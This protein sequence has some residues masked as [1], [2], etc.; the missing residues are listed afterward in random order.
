MRKLVQLEGIGVKF[1]ELLQQAGIEDQRELLEA[2]K[3][4]KGRETLAQET[5][6]NP[7]LLL[8]WTQQADLARI[9]GIG[10]DYAELLEQSGVESIPA[11]AQY[12]ARKL[13]TNME[14]I[15]EKNKLVKHM[16][17]ISLI[18]SWISQAKKLPSILE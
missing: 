10:E 18:K 4:H 9:N 12:D 7:K 15:N 16:P 3:N 1:I 17:S 5:G 8:K 14:I 13:Y 6:I 11:L 2:C